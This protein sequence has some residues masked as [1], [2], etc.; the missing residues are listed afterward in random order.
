MELQTNKNEDWN[1]QKNNNIS[2]KIG[3]NFMIKEAS[4]KSLGA[5][6]LAVTGMEALYA[7]LG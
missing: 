6:F 5:V 1:A 2:I 4:F 3:I 7:D